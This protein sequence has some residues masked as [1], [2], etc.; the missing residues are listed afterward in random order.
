MAKRVSKH[1][2]GQ[3]SDLVKN[4]PAEVDTKKL[5]YEAAFRL[6]LAVNEQAVKDAER[7]LLEMYKKPNDKLLQLQYRDVLAEDLYP[8]FCDNLIPVKPTKMMKKIVDRLMA[9]KG[10]K[11]MP[12]CWAD[13]L[14]MIAEMEN[15]MYA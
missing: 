10:L 5:T 6:A 8:F 7:I 1:P 9:K 4:M 11:E 2:R 15:F 13:E 3:V 12:E 14:Y